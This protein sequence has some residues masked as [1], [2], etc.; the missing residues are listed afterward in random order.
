MP[1]IIINN[2]SD[3]RKFEIT[4]ER[5]SSKESEVRRGKVNIIKPIK[6]LE[7]DLE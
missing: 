5:S 3:D 4:P 1:K 6:I 2:G 7:N